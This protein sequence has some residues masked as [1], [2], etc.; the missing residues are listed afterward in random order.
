[1]GQGRE[2]AGVVARLCIHRVPVFTG[3]LRDRIF[4]R[5]TS[6]AIC[7]PQHVTA[8]KKVHGNVTTVHIVDA[9]NAIFHVVQVVAGHGAA[10]TFESRNHALGVR[11]RASQLRILKV[12]EQVRFGHADWLW[13]HF[14]FI[15]FVSLSY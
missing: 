10:T 15:G 6:I 14:R 12:D 4:A 13:S 8:S 9:K 7:G 5:T 2:G 1:M 3:F 11:L